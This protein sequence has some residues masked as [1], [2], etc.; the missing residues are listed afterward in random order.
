V[1]CR[2]GHNAVVDP[3]VGNF[4][5]TV[6][7]RLEWTLEVDGLKRTRRQ[8]PIRRGLRRERVAEHC[9]HLAVATI[10][11][12]PVARENV[13]VERAALLATLHDFPEL[14]EGDSSVY[15]ARELTR[16]A[17]ELRAM[18]RFR[19]GAGA[20]FGETIFRAWEDY[21]RLN[22]P[23]GRLVLAL[24][25]ILPVLLNHANLNRSS[26]RVGKTRVTSQQVHAR[27]DRAEQSLPE[28]TAIAR[29][30]VEDAERRQGFVRPWRRWALFFL[31]AASVGGREQRR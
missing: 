21:E 23:E 13:D 20:D 27:L 29:E 31:P 1:W 26:W 6:A 17:R 24:D 18:E 8:N 16:P 28:L 10:I 30:L 4:E 25:V 2:F 11:W 5:P 9:W 3:G 14:F 22:G 19:R 15:S 12:A 7:A